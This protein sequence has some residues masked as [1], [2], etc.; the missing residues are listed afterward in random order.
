MS[1]ARVLCVENRP[2]YLEVLES[3]LEDAGYDV[4]SATNGSE[5]LI[6]FRELGID[7]VLLEYDLPDINGS[8]LRSEMKRMKPDVPVLLFAG[9]GTHTPFLLRFF[10]S[11]I[12]NSERPDWALQD[13]DA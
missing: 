1:F 4:I 13:M 8:T 11:Y 10:D 12:R 7:G 2:E 3:I 9:V 6:L 5:A